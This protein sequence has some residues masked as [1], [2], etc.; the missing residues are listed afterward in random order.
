M[1]FKKVYTFY[2]KDNKYNYIVSIIEQREVHR[3]AIRIMTQG[4][5]IIGSLS[6]SADDQ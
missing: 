6:L 4:N 5:S 1:V 3:I 2:T